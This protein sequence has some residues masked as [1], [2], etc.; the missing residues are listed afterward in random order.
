[1][2]HSCR[3]RTRDLRG[4]YQLLGEC[5]ELGADPL[6]WRQHLVERLPALLGG[7]LG[8]YMEV[9]VVGQPFGQPFWLAPLASLD[10]GW[11]TPSDR[12]PFDAHLATGRPED[13]PHITPDLLTR[14]VKTVQWAENPAC[15]DWHGSYFFNAYVKHTHLD[16][17]LMAHQLVGPGQMRWLIAN[18]ARG[19]RHFSVRDRRLMKLLNLE[20]IRL[21][22]HRLARL[23]E[24]S[25]SDLPPRLR[26]VLICLMNGDSEKQA[27]LKLGLSRYTV[28][29]YVKLLHA[30]FGVSSRGELLSRCRA[31]WPVLERA[32]QSSRPFQSDDR[33]EYDADFD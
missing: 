27:A 11:G 3:L 21:L 17:G 29:D 15:P 25:V 6:A 1:M 22:G 10:F 16:D 5:C 33:A 7:Q 4:V 30:R 12:K 23:G 31:F 18:R 20:L 14:R 19:D 13:G 9:R 32:A 24:P 8:H 26:E 2:A 28:H